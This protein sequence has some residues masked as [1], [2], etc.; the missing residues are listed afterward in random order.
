MSHDGF[1]SRCYGACLTSPMPCVCAS[2]TE[3][4]FAY[5]PG[6]LVKEKFL[7]ECI[8][9]KREPEQ[10]HY[11]CCRECPPEKSKYEKSSVACKGHL[12]P[13]FIKE[14]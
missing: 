2:E 4:Q 13:K 12:L 6:G 14:C 1:C 11:F 9:W 3:G 7:E 5:T 8:A 10:H